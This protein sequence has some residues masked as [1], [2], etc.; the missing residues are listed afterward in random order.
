MSRVINTNSPTK[1]RNY[2]RRTIAEL[3]R[4]LSRRPTIDA[5]AQDMLAAIVFALRTIQSVNL[6]SAAAWEKRGYWMKAE[7]FMRDWEW[8]KLT[9]YDLEDVLRYEAWDL[10]PR[11]VLTLL[12][13]FADIQVKNL[14]RSADEWQGAYARLIAEPPSEP[15]Y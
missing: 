15:P 2:Q 3:L 4:H 14:T 11:L 9:A 8:V 10:A 1:Q 7:R 6:E 5:E 12:P 13:H